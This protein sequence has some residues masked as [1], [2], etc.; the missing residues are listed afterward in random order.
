MTKLSFYMDDH[1]LLFAWLARAVLQKEPE[2]GVDLV[3]AWVTTYGRE[4]G[5]RSARRC[6]DDMQ[7]LSLKNYFVYSEWHDERGWNRNQVMSLAPYHFY[8]TDCGW[9]KTW[10]EHGLQE[11][12]KLYCR[13]VDFAL[14]EGFNPE[15]RLEMVSTLSSGDR[16]CSFFWPGQAFSDEDLKDMA[17]RRAVAQTRVTRDFLYH[18][19]HLYDVLK[20]VLI[21]HLGIEAA[22]EIMKQGL[23]D[24]SAVFGPEKTKAL[25]KLSAQNF[26]LL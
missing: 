20:R 23:D 4:R 8:T 18:L 11:Y 5:A 1:A 2:D 6:L 12:G 21:P 17:E 15:L 14:V 7:S 22:T 25:L 3:E 10:E 24:Y 13:W 9:N 19:T 26:S 16:Q